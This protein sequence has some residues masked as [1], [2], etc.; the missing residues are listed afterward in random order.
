MFFL[1]AFAQS[2]PAYAAS[3]TAQLTDY[4]KVTLNYTVS[5]PSATVSTIT[6]NS[7][8]FQNTRSS[9]T[10]EATRLTA[11]LRNGSG[12]TLLT[13]C[14]NTSIT[15][16]TKNK[17]F[18][19]SSTYNF[20]RG[21]ST[22]NQSLQFYAIMTRPSDNH[23]WSKTV[24]FT[25]SITA[26]PSY[27]V[28][29]DLNGGDSASIPSQT[30]W[31]DEPLTLAADIPTR[32]GYRFISW[33]TQRNDTGTDYSPGTNY[34]GNAELTLY[35]QWSDNVPITNI[36]TAG[37]DVSAYKY[38]PEPGETYDSPIAGTKF[39]I[40]EIPNLNGG[41][42][43]AISDLPAALSTRAGFEAAFSIDDKKQ[44]LTYDAAALSAAGLTYV[45][46]MTTGADGYATTSD[47]PL[48]SGHAY[49]I[50][51][52][53]CP[54]GYV[55]RDARENASSTPIFYVVDDV[56]ADG[57]PAH[58]F[59]P[60]N[61]TDTTKAGTQIDYSSTDAL[62]PPKTK[63][64]STTVPGFYGYKVELSDTPSVQADQEQS[65][66][67]ERSE[68]HL[69]GVTVR[70]CTAEDETIPLAGAMFAIYPEDE[71]N[72][73]YAS[74][75]TACSQEDKEP[76]DAEFIS[77]VKS[78]NLE[79]EGDAPEDDDEAE[80]VADD[81]N[82]SDD[83]EPVGPVSPYYIEPAVSLDETDSLGFTFTSK[84]AIPL[85]S[86]RVVEI[87]P[88]TG[89]DPPIY[90]F[91]DPA[92]GNTGSSV[93]EV[94]ENTLANA[95]T[96]LNPKSA[97]VFSTPEELS[98]GKIFTDGTLEE[99]M[100][101]FGL[102]Q[103]D[104]TVIETVSN[105]APL[106]KHSATIPLGQISYIEAE[107]K[108][109][110]GAPDTGEVIWSSAVLG[111]EKT[112]TFIVREIVPS[113][114]TCE[115]DDSGTVWTYQDYVNRNGITDAQWYGWRKGNTVYDATVGKIVVTV[116][117][118]DEM[119]FLDYAYQGFSGNFT[120]ALDRD[121]AKGSITLKK[122]DRSG[123]PLAHAIFS[124]LDTRGADYFYDTIESD[125][126]G[127]ATIDRLPNGT[128]S[129]RE[130]TAPEGYTLNEDWN[131]QVTIDDTH[132]TWDL[133]TSNPC[134]ND[135]DVPPPTGFAIDENTV[136]VLGAVFAI[137][138]LALVGRKQ[139]V[140]KSRFVSSILEE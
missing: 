97:T 14:N 11:T 123:A 3:V 69:G 116:F 100:F 75:L 16:G 45:T 24:N 106:S 82:E 66:R 43:S 86:Y 95:G 30:K 105:P 29:Y 61:Y 124:V 56:K 92:A 7:V 121:F 47:A 137:A 54:T 8:V 94:T 36:Y 57:S 18:D 71:F 107:D 103:E 113:D 37:F 23:S 74:Y 80:P 102:Y 111:D 79:V 41:A 67:N 70:K 90:D 26:R 132:R 96:F 131:P 89:Y 62:Q 21:H 138:A 115:V 44:N 19:L 53:S 130:I 20:T 15:K 9:G 129:I 40:F 73:K 93:V 139:Q 125:E 98:I 119:S 133:S 38:G 127:I 99:G 17:T 49:A 104:N 31:H 25:I 76:S 6:I 60:E 42:L 63:T 91:S 81:G 118:N 114:A 88:P 2:T 35:A 85:G 1:V 13:L 109:E 46:S 33:N 112:V 28:S 122:Q 64:D 134:N 78:E 12:T 48:E 59:Y 77:L 136:L 117:D 135:P 84:A 87:Q 10:T 50:I 140:R 51:E 22:A 65:F 101:S 27:I 34:T 120:N 126:N 52:V 5:T 128:Y 32:S 72:A 58:V 55:L 108:I 4:T 110:L 39:D 83:P 68:E